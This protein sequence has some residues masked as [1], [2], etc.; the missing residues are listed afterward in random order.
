MIGLISWILL[1]ASLWAHRVETLPVTGAAARGR[2][3][4]PGATAPV[5]PM[6]LPQA[7][8]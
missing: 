3:T 1:G 7:A 6:S 2:R 4:L 5:V 8:P